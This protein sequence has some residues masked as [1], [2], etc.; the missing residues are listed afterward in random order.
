MLIRSSIYSRII[1][2][3]FILVASIVTIN[4][5]SVWSLSRIGKAIHDVDTFQIPL[6]EHVTRISELQAIQQ[7]KLNSAA[8]RLGIG[9][10][11]V[12]EKNVEEMRSYSEATSTELSLMK[13]LLD[14]RITLYNQKAQNNFSVIVL[15][16]KPLLEAE[17]FQGMVTQT[18]SIAEGQKEFE[19][20]NEKFLT[21]LIECTGW[22]ECPHSELLQE[23]TD[24]LA[25]TQ[26]TMS[27]TL[28]DFVESVE[29]LTK[30][31]VSS[32]QKIERN[33][34]QNTII[35]ALLAIILAFFVGLRIAY[36][37]KK[38]LS[39][40]VTSIDDMA[41]GNLGVKIE[42]TGKDE[43]STVLV[44]V[45]KMRDGMIEVVKG[46]LSLTSELNSHSEKLKVS[47][48][49]VSMTTTE[50][51]TSVQETSS[52][53]QEMAASIQQNAE[54][55][56]T[57]D[58]MASGLSEDAAI[59]S[60]AMEK[61]ATSMKNIAEKITVVEE[62]TRKIE[63]LA[64]NASVEAARAGEHGKGFAVVASEVS[65]LAELSKQ[66][67]GDIQ[68]SSSEGKE[69]SESTNKMLRELLPEIDKT[70]DLVQGIR[71]A[72]DEQAIGANQI[73][74]AVQSLDNSIQNNASSASNLASIGQTVAELSPK[75]RNLVS[76][77]Q[78]E[79]TIE[80]SDEFSETSEKIDN[81]HG[82]NEIISKDFKSF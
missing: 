43:V 42:T 82:L 81:D 24:L 11:D 68:L 22:N 49:E 48:T 62:I 79:E 57:S 50:Q 69:M 8:F 75:L 10:K 45:L 72:S 13:N 46:L 70:R 35:I 51:S 76:F 2:L 67:A 65:K 7:L 16:E 38:R 18:D 31:G 27:V 74:S 56:S 30:R 64:L 63:L 39:S 6:L 47:A 36:S 12:F 41:S 80:V 73:T 54:A 78:L 19:V 55:A 77:F 17:V 61:T 4:T 9:Q 28:N 15:D 53:V 59:C 66:A 1:T 44:S 52:A 40:V 58:Q 20:L 32:A 21:E 71:A 37:V 14:K 34:F 33:S 25:Q 60:Q 26:T 5:F 3:V 23:L 29:G